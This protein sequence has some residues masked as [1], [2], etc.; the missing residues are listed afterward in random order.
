MAS[1]GLV[2]TARKVNSKFC[3]S[4]KMFN[5]TEDKSQPPRNIIECSNAE[6]YKYDDYLAIS[7][8]KSLSYV[9]VVDAWLGESGE[10]FVWRWAI[11]ATIHIPSLLYTSPYSVKRHGVP[12][13]TGSLSWA[14][15]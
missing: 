4:Y 2:S 10:I 7:V 13:P 15:D 5:V 8:F 1:A 3:A 14:P 9:V 12:I 11:L 6:K